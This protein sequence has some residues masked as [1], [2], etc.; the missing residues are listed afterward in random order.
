M[1]EWITNLLA[2]DEGRGGVL[3]SPKA[4]GAFM[5]EL[6]AQPPV[7]VLRMAAQRF[8]AL[9]EASLVRA[10]VRRSV[11]RLDEY[12]QRALRECW[13]SM[14]SGPRGLTLSE[15][16]W[17]SLR[18]YYRSVHARYA[19]FLRGPTKP[20]PA[21]EQEQAD[22]IVIAARAMSALAKHMLLLHMRYRQADRLVWWH[23]RDLLEWA[24]AHGHYTAAL[25]LY[26]DTGA[27][28][29]FERELLTALLIEV[30]PT[31]NLLPAQ[32]Q[33][34][35][36]LLRLHDGAFRMSSSH[37]DQA[38]PFGYD[39]AKGKA[40][41][42][43]LKQLPVYPGLRFFGVGSAYVAL[44]AEKESAVSPQKV[45]GWLASTRCSS[46]DYRDLL[47]RLVSAWS[48]RP[49]ARRHR[50]EPCAGEILVA[51]D[52]SEIRRLVKFSELARAGRSN[53]YDSTNI[54]GVDSSPRAPKDR[55]MDDPTLKKPV[56]IPEPLANLLS[57]ERTVADE[58]IETWSLTDSSEVGLGAVARSPR[59]WVK[60]GMLI[61][62]RDPDSPDW[63]LALIRRLNCSDV[64]DLTVGMTRVK[65]TV[66][67]A[68]LRL[69]AGGVH[70]HP[71]LGGNDPT[72][73]EYDALVVRDAEPSLFIPAGVFDRSW[74]Y[75]LYWDNRQD[76][77]KMEK[78]LEC[79]L[80][81]ER[82]HT[83]AVEAMRAA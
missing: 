13:E 77:V 30:A 80:N 42:R 41:Q 25:E 11:M 27:Q 35:D 20:K 54:Y 47:E 15:D 17:A 76:V 22:A 40:P 53:S 55:T 61:A 51:H 36:R 6:D 52:W 71:A 4:L 21:S 48:L 43:W 29:T 7:R 62:F 10:E 44:C 19:S 34:L 65:G 68:R 26:P 33:A 79:G 58:A 64:G 3:G 72:A 46:E 1:F 63:Q 38:T 73:I 31:S 57:F 82:V 14:L 67:S 60:V 12:A 56:V 8:D 69:G 18:G 70:R 74:K 75:T 59:P 66:A 50:R 32:V 28:T 9:P 23:V 45:P 37:D 39:P 78:S 81:F 83:T 24:E 49:P 5:A 16:M 2:P